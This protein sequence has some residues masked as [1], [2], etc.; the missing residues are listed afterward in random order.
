MMQQFR[1]D[2]PPPKFLCCTINDSKI[3]VESESLLGAHYPVNSETIASR[4]TAPVTR[5]M[6]SCL[7]CFKRPDMSVNALLAPAFAPPPTPPF[8]ANH[9]CLPRHRRS[10]A[11]A[12]RRTACRGGFGRCLTL[13]SNFRTQALQVVLPVFLDDGTRRARAARSPPATRSPPLCRENHRS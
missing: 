3:Q 9:E 5:C 10:P 2:S 8:T 6:R 4:R 13:P 1:R 11:L 12:A 7:V